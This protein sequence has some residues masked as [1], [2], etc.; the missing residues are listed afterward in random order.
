MATRKQRSKKGGAPAAP[1]PE[2]VKKEKEKA[3]VL[4]DSVWWQNL[5]AKGECNYCGQTF[6]KKD[7]T[8]DHIVPLSRG[9][10][11]TKG[12]VVVACQ[13]CNSDKKYYTAAE[14][15]LKNRMDSKIN[16]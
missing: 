12:N 7:L 2:S 8:M 11:S 13:P 3:R 16:F 6:A 9:G 5:L 1:S 15:I 14:L 10:K 4:R